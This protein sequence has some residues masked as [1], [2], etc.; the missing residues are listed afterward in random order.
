LLPLYAGFFSYD[1][2]TFA[3]TALNTYI[4]AWGRINGR[5]N[6]IVYKNGTVIWTSLL[7]L[8][9]NPTS[10]FISP[11]GGY[12]ALATQ[13]SNGDVFLTIFKGA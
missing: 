11:D 4:A 2:F 1:T 9:E 12:I 6:L 3:S 13:A 7:T 8:G 10:V 5:L